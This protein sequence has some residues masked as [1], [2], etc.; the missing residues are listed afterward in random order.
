M[1]NGNDGAGTARRQARM[2]AAHGVMTALLIMGWT[3][4]RAAETCQ[5][6]KADS[7]PVKMVGNQPLVPL[8]ING[9][10]VRFLVDTGA[11]RS[12]IQRNKAKE[13]GLPAFT[14]TV[15]YMS[16]VGGLS[17]IH[18]TQVQSLTLG[19][20][21]AHDVHLVLMGDKDAKEDDP[22]VLGGDIVGILG[23]DVLSKFDL[24]FDLAHDVLNLYQP[25]GCQNAFLAFW[26]EAA[27]MAEIE[28]LDYDSPHIVLS[29][30]INGQKVRT[31][32]DS[33]AT[34]SVLAMAA[35]ARAGLT[36]D[37]PSTK[38]AGTSHGIGSKAVTTWIGTFD[39]I[40]IGEETVRH[41]KLAFSDLQGDAGEEAQKKGLVSNGRAKTEMLLGADF[42]MAHHVLVARSQNRLYF[43]HNG[44]PIFNVT[45]RKTETAPPPQ[46]PASGQ[47][48]TAQ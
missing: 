2:L 7:L 24:E 29:V 32:L 3:G 9:H 25:R 31:H 15:G 27:L 11:Y 30:E 41:A 46:P 23:E 26:S 47:L 16:G 10:P 43:T 21:T 28:P 37:S 13:L 4:A 45:N 33:G 14:N 39:S 36:P 5:M 34:H 19:Q 1:R 38:L 20:Q 48:Q 35:A 22:S 18:S 40:T 12:A 44:G 8:Q 42:L 17:E 6:I